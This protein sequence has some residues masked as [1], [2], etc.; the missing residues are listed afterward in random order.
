MP[1]RNCVLFTNKTCCHTDKIADFSYMFQQYLTL[2]YL[3]GLKLKL[4]CKN[5]AFY[6]YPIIHDIVFGVYPIAVSVMLSCV[7]DIS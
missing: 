7:Q 2:L 4:N 5:C 3:G 1:V 6:L